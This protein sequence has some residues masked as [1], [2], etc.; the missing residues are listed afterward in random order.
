MAVCGL[1]WLIPAPR[2]RLSPSPHAD[3]PCLQLR[4]ADAEMLIPAFGELQGRAARQDLDGA[5]HNAAKED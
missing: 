5:Q 4:A 2:R 1:L 3:P